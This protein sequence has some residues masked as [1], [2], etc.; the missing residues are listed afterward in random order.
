MR[1]DRFRTRT[2]KSRG[3]I[4]ID[5]DPDA[6]RKVIGSLT[7][8]DGKAYKAAVRLGLIKQMAPAP[9]AEPDRP[10]RVYGYIRMST[11]KQ[12]MSP[13]VQRKLICQHAA[14]HGL[15]V[16]QFFTDKAV[17]GGKPMEERPAGRDLMARLRRGDTI[18]AAK[19]DR[20]FRSNIDFSINLDRWLRQGVKCIFCDIGYLDMQTMHGQLV[21]T[22]LAAVAQFE[23]QIISTRTKE[24][25]AHLQ[26]K[27]YRTT[28]HT[29]L[30]FRWK[31]VDT[32][33]GR[34]LIEVPDD[35]E[36]ALMKYIVQ[37]RLNDPPIEFTEIKRVFDEKGIVVPRNNKPWSYDRIRAAFKAELRLQVQEMPRT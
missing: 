3:P 11:V 17:S 29:R 8:E 21:L 5:H 25:I 7:P 18:I 26:R 4:K 37:C 2:G 13:E 36:R 24:G 35:N 1:R 15:T 33:E 16:D 19:L 23:R 9:A 12:D 20:V 27:G 22:I 6:N 30:G 10:A 31:K 32:P 28:R 34:K 14:G